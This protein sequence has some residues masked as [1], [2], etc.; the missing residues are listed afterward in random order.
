M[1]NRGSV[2]QDS[3]SAVGRTAAVPVAL[4]LVAL[5]PLNHKH[6]CCGKPVLLASYGF[7]PDT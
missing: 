1:S 5:L 4:R 3:E 2:R 6:I 7:I